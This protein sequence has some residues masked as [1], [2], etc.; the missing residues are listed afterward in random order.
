MRKLY[1]FIDSAC[2]FTLSPC[3]HVNCLLPQVTER[4]FYIR[5]HETTLQ[6][7][8]ARGRLNGIP[9]PSLW[10]ADLGRPQWT[11]EGRARRTAGTEARVGP[12]PWSLL[13]SLL[14]KPQSRQRTDH[15]DS[16]H[17]HAEISFPFH[18]MIARLKGLGQQKAHIHLLTIKI[19]IKRGG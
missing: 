7:A 13:P 10:N 1:R 3:T 16:F 9:S 2:G 15:R 11:E 6:G 8:E 12:A 14:T 17:V 19:K 5:G 4:G 18:I